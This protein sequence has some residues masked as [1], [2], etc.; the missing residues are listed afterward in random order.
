[1]FAL[2]NIAQ[3]VIGYAILYRSFANIG[4]PGACGPH[5]LSPVQS[6]YFS[7]VTFAT[8]GFGDL[9]PLDDF[10]RGLVVSEICAALMIVALIIPTVLVGIGT[11]LHAKDD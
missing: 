2:I 4:A 6:L 11:R 10:S 9:A 8:V 3:L 1:M 5:V 7:M